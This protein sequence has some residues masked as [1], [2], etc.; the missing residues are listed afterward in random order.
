TGL[1]VRGER[2]T[3]TDVQALTT[4]EALP[5]ARVSLRGL[6]G[7]LRGTVV[8]LHPIEAVEADTIPD[9]SLNRVGRLA[10]FRLLHDV[11]RL[12]LSP[13]GDLLVGATRARIRFEPYQYV[14]AARA[15]E[16]PRPRLPRRASSS[17]N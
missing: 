17:W 11:F 9:L 3:V 1:S 4:G 15:L 12:R 10:R 16:L 2:C 6:D 8:V 5:L 13:P 14:P 7:E